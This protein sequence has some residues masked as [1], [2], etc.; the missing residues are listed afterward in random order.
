MKVVDGSGWTG[1]VG[2]SGAV[3]VSGGWVMGVVCMCA[4][5]RVRGVRA[6]MYVCVFGCVCVCVCVRA[7][8]AELARACGRTS[9]RVCVCVGVCWLVRRYRVLVRICVQAPHG[10]L[11]QVAQVKDVLVFVFLQAR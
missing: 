6:G 7:L 9:K 4:C 11:N 3:W 2:V 10:L 5:V 8:L 1:M